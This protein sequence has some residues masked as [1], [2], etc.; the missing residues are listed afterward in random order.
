MEPQSLPS[1]ND[2]THLLL[3]WTAGD[4]AA[5]CVLTPLIYDELHRIA[6]GYMRRE[7][8]YLTL[9]ATALV[10]EAW[11]R[12]VDV[13]NVQWQ[14]R[15]HFFAISAQIMRRILVDF[16]RSRKVAKRG[17]GVRAVELDAALTECRGTSDFVAIDDA[18]EALSTIDPRKSKVVELR[19]F[20]GLSVEETAEALRISTDTVLRD[21]KFAKSWLLRELSP[22]SSA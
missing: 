10:N 21:W 4:S 3:A 19:F 6:A 9:Q 17:G 13:R 11:L 20:G 16:A 12:L 8:D 5:L 7:R 18:L 1:P 15:A 22:R 14:S 2:V